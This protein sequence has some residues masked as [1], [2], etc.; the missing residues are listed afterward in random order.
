MAA[1]A[2]RLGR[3]MQGTGLILMPLAVIAGEMQGWDLGP[4]LIA[5]VVGFLLI[6]TGRSLAS[7]PNG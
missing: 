7:D 4:I 2:P 1:K 5:A 3:A 6:L